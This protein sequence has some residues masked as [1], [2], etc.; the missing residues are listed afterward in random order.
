V[1]TMGQHTS[2]SGTG[3]PFPV[4]RARPGRDADLSPPS[5]AEIK[6]EYEL[7]F[8]FPKAPLWR[9]CGAAVA[10][11]YRYTQ[12]NHFSETKFMRLVYRCYC[13][14]VGFCF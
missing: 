9:R 12:T 4:A 11:Q 5:S 14:L 13:M 3:G 6:N 1:C 10:F 8:L 7:Y 2:G